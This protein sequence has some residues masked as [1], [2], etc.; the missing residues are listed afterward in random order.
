MCRAQDNYIVFDTD[1]VNY[2]SMDDLLHGSGYGIFRSE[3]V[4]RLHFVEQQQHS[5]VVGAIPRSAMT[6]I[7]VYGVEIEV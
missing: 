7:V 2:I 5:L 3:M 4:G 6:K 1:M